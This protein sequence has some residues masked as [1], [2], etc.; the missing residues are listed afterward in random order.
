MAALQGTTDRCE[1][2]S[3]LKLIC[4]GD[5]AAAASLEALRLAHVG[6]ASLRRLAAFSGTLRHLILPDL[7]WLASLGLPAAVSRLP[8]LLVSPPACHPA[9]HPACRSCW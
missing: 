1:E 7:A 4:S 8:A 2:A 6:G 5:G 3:L 9:C